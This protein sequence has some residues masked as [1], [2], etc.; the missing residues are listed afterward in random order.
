MNGTYVNEELRGARRAGEAPE[1]A[2]HRIFPSVDLNDGDRIHVGQ[3][4]IHVEVERV[5]NRSDTLQCPICVMCGNAAPG[6]LR[7][8]E[9]AYVCARCREQVRRD[10]KMLPEFLEATDEEH[11]TMSNSPSFAD[12]EV[13]EKLGQG[14]WRSCTRAVTGDAIAWSH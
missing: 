13:G 12:I 4:V 9:G 14:G 10:P 11:F 6:E 1:D 8:S 2:V 5:G 7:G 3:T